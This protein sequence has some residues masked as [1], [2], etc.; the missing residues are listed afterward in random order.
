MAILSKG[1]MVKMMLK[2]LE[3]LPT[4]ITPLKNAVIH[5]LGTI[6][7][8]SN[9]RDLNAAWTDTKKKAVKLYPDKFILDNRNSLCWND[10][11]VIVLDKKITSANFKKLNELADLEGRNVNSMVSKLIS[12][13]KKNNK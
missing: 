3:E 1:R 2:H 4:G 13:Y 12:F 11:S 10:G 6:A 5:R 8:L 9:I 7:A